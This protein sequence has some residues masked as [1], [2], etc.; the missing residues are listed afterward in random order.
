VSTGPKKEADPISVTPH[1][2]SRSHPYRMK[3]RVR[4]PDCEVAFAEERES[5]WL[6][7][8]AGEMSAYLREFA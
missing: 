2:I 6:V 5:I 4:Q 8:P 7:P 3:K 1:Q